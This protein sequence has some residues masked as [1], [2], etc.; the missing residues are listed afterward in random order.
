MSK[1][2][3]I[4]GHPDLS[5]SYTNSV[6]LNALESSDLE[7][8]VRRLH[9]LYPDFD[10]D[11]EQEQQALISADVI[12][13]Q[14]P[15]YW[16]SVPGLLKHWLDKVFT[17]NFAYGT[18]G[19]KLKGKDFVL[20]FTIGGSEESYQPLGY[21]HFSIE[22]LVL[23]LQQTAY[24]AGINFQKP[25]YSHR[26]VF[27]P[28]VYNTQEE[29][30]ARANQHAERLIDTLTTLTDSAKEK[31]ARFVQRWF[32]EFDQLPEETQFFLN[33]MD[34]NI[35]LKMPEGQFEG[36]AG[37]R[38]WYTQAQQ[39]FKPGC[40]HQVGQLEINELGDNQYEVKLQIRLIAET[41]SNESFDLSVNETWRLGL[42]A[43]GDIRISDYR[44]IAV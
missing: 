30:E 21:N 34:E 14:Y 42:N 36:H 18:E 28:G 3:V 9:E 24:L 40:D 44:V 29:V 1:V 12:V 31:I 8:E 38:D 6:I 37:F 43:A 16:Y 5:K 17:F 19:D 2:V 20:S 15:F 7:V 35:H 22:Q 25:V 39:M 10:I 26:M 4:A 41:Q 23:P 32:A 27:I 11:V 13:L 33:H